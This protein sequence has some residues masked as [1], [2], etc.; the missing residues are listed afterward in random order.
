MANT[1]AV[2]VRAGAKSLH[3]NWLTP[4]APEFDL[5][6]LAYEPPPASPD[7]TAIH[8]FSI[9]GRKIAGYNQ[10]FLEN[11]E[12]LDRY[13]QIALIDNDILCT[14]KEIN[15]AFR[16]GTEHGFWLW[17][18]TLTL[19][20][21]F[22]FAILLRN[23]LLKLR[24]VT[25]IE[26]MCP[27]FSSE[28]LKLSLKLFGLGYETGID[29]IWCRIRENSDRKYAVLDEV[30]VK[31]TLPI[32]GR[33]HLQGFVGEKRDYMVTTRE[34]EQ[35]FGAPPRRAV[36]YAALTKSGRLIRG[37]LPIALLSL[38]IYSG[39]FKNIRY[40]RLYFMKIVTGHI[41]RLLSSPID[42][43]KLNAFE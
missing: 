40:G 15:A 43:P 14:S 22:S 34:V 19:D 1:N 11:P 4:E 26:M 35:R 18:P 5:Y 30:T 6:V 7:T 42:N 21:Y 10:F 41:V 2:I 17:Q 16:A 31:H 3:P 24:Y 23:P 39:L 36:A 32:G 9:P 28:H 12:I 33:A 25:F 20:S 37:R 8:E 27:F 13:S 38:I 29:R